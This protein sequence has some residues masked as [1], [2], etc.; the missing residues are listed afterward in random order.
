MRE[1]NVGIIGFGFMG[2]AH[3]YA[4][5]AI[6]FYYP[7]FKSKIKLSA[8]CSAH[9]SN[10][11]NAKST[12]GFEYA[13][14]NMYDILD[15]DK[16]NVVN[17]CTPNA[18]HKDA[19]IAALRAGKHI[20]C[21]KPL[22]VT[23]KEAMEIVGEHKKSSSIVQVTF[24]NRFFPATL[25]AKQI[26]NEGKLGR[27]LSFRAC[28]LH[29]GSIDPQRPIG[30]RYDKNNGGGVLF[31]M[32]VHILDL[33]YH[34]LGEF[35]GIFC[36]MQTIYEKRPDG[37]GNMVD[38]L[39]DDASYMTLETKGG[40]VGT[41]E[42]SKI[43]TGANDDLRFEIHGDK[44]A[45]RFSLMEPSFLE[46]YDNTL[47]EAAYGGNK[48]F[49]RIEC[50]SRYPESGFPGPKYAVGWIRGHIHSL[51]SFLD[52]IENGKTPSPSSEEA[53]YIQYVME[54]ACLSAKSGM[55]LKL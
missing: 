55:Y 20:Y 23:Y 29:S 48:G 16:I 19:V 33:I 47:P 26:V 3:T 36:K 46:Y 1:I 51:Y 9:L 12:F 15:D 6:P 11:E 4:Y 39:T 8:V 17:I 14:D 31:D 35:D 22:A 21:D 18:L 53:A 5:N 2:K 7:N 27:I 45:I 43:A 54:K 42:A 24:Q 13:T 44:G 52:C 28:Y 34:L 49:T 50:V 10:A 41:V 38:I 25:R 40:A 37:A 30:W 32:G